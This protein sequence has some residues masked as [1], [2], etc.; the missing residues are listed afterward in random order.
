[1]ADFKVKLPTLGDDAPD[2][3]TL[4]F[5]YVEEGSEVT[6]DDDFCEMVTDKAT[7]NVPSPVTGTVKSLAV[8]EDDI[9]EVGG[10][11]AIVETAE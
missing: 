5:Y 4:S 1:M 10:L 7:F 3:A 2:E 9:V 8:E 6:K 11:L